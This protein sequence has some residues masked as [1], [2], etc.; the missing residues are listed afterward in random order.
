MT[1]GG[2]GE[3]PNG[4]GKDKAKSRNTGEKDVIRLRPNP[5]WWLNDKSK[6]GIGKVERGVPGEMGREGAHEGNTDKAPGYR[7]VGSGK[8]RIQE[9]GLSKG[10][11]WKIRE[12]E[13]CSE[14]EK[15]MRQVTGQELRTSLQRSSAAES[16]YSPERERLK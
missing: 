6:I 11:R 13:L 12:G 14:Q 1:G 4:E 2:G 7:K 5:A 3:P 15:N 9:R 16:C 10:D 8:K